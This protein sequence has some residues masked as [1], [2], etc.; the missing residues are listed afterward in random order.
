[1]VDEVMEGEVK[2][3]MWMVENAKFGISWTFRLYSV[4]FA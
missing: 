4:V 3:M 2:R 1:M